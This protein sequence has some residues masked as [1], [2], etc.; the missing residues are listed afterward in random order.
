MGISP[1]RILYANPVKTESSLTWA[2]HHKIRRVTFDCEDELK[3][4][5]GFDL[6]LRIST[7]DKESRCSLSEKFGVSLDE[8]KYLIDLCAKNDLPLIGITFHCGSGCTKISSYIE[9][10]ENS[11]LL[12]GYAL[13]RGIT[14]QVLD[15]GGG[16]P[17]DE[18][19][20]AE[21]ADDINK[22]LLE[23]PYKEIIAEPGRF[24]VSEAYTLYCQIIGEKEREGISY[25]TLTE[26]VY[27][28]FNSI[29]FDH[30]QPEPLPVVDEEEKEERKEEEYLATFFG[31]TCDSL[32]TILKKYPMKTINGQRL[33]R[34]DWIYFKS[35]GAYT[36]AAGGKFNGFEP[37]KCI[38][39]NS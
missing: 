21:I 5:N 13:L 32:D 19:K 28:S 18:R 24:V 34:G 12:Y 7:D 35:M 20:F 39:L 37:A 29:I 15:I 17:A 9:S 1:D 22:K 33:K 8:A 36:I 27:A 38:Y 11:I 26:G 6:L 10:I 30:Y 23:V 14:L 3:K 16:F 2:R 25:F 31:P 4:C